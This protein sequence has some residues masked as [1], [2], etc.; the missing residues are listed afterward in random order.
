[1]SKLLM[2]TVRG[3]ISQFGADIKECHHYVKTAYD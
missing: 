1:M 3:R 2:I